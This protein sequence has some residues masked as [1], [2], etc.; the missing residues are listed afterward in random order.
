MPDEILIALDYGGTKLSAAMARRGQRAWLALERVASP[1]NKDGAYDRATML[2]MARRLLAGRAPA[3]IG[4][5]FG[6]PVDAARGRVILS[7]HVPG[8]EDTPLREQLQDALGAPASVDNDANVGA[9]GEY[10]FGAGQGCSSLLYVTVSTGIG[11]GWIL[12]GKIWS[13]ADA[14][15]GEIGHTICD[16]RGPECVCGR[17]GCVEAMA[18]GPAIAR[19][20]RERLNQNPAQGR[21]LRELAG[22]NLNAMT[23]AIVAQAANAGDELA[24]AVMDD[25]AR[26]LGFGIGTAI[27]LVN[28]ERVVIGGGV[29]KSGERWWHIVRESAR[30]NTLPQ[31][32]TDIVP[33]ALGDDAP[34]WGAIALAEKGVV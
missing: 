32:R 1:P 26:A 5:S 9:L 24:R 17:R 14:M 3:A 33:A 30:K 13:G 7:H 25:A 31:I 23:G 34:L 21:E 4:V 18:C 27:T 11:G 29:T 8:W 15:A 20:A 28:P 22:N 10:T 6:G 16:P 12:G 19:R 2:A